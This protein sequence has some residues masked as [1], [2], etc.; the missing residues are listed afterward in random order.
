MAHGLRSRWHSLWLAGGC[1]P[2][3]W[4]LE[5]V[6]LSGFGLCRAC[7]PCCSGYLPAT[8]VLLLVSE[9]HLPC[10]FH[11]RMK[12]PPFAS[13]LAARHVLAI[14]SFWWCGRLFRAPPCCP[15]FKSWPTAPSRPHMGIMPH[16]GGSFTF[17]VRC[18]CGQPGWLLAYG[19]GP[20]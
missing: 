9:V 6:G 7:A 18:L 17:H 14:I 12:T 2:P 11:R 10:D 16:S 19:S 13:V 20:L 4:W 5:F 3:Y 15:V 8:V 1:L